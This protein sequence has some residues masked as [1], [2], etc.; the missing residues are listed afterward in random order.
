MAHF[1]RWAELAAL[2]VIV[3]VNV[4]LIIQAL[5][6]ARRGGPTESDG[7]LG[8]ALH[9]AAGS[10]SARCADQEAAAGS[11]FGILADCSM[12]K[13]TNVRILSGTYRRLT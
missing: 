11:K 6:A 3:A 12:M 2:A 9:G 13:S 4:R 5:Q 7:A 10:S 8:S 1:L